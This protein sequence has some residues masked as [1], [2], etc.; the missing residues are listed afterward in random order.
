MHV[1]AFL[2]IDLI[3]LDQADDV[4]CLIQLTAPM[5]LEITQRPG[6]ALVIVLDRSGS[7]SGEPLDGALE[8]IAGLVRRLAPQDAFGLVTFDSQADVVVPV[9]AMADHDAAELDR[10]IRGIRSGGSTDLS[11]GYLLGVREA[12]RALHVNGTAGCSGIVGATVLLVSDGH[13]NAGI[14]DPVVM[15]GLAHAANADHAITTSTLGFGLGY[16]EVLLEAITRGGNGEHRFA[17]DVD[18]CMSE[19]ADAATDLLGKSVLGALLRIMPQPGLVGGVTVRNDVPH[20]VEG[21]AVVVNIGDLYGGEERR[22]LFRLHVPALPSLGLATIADVVLEFTSLPDLQ[23]HS[24]T[25][26]VSVNVVPGDQAAGRIPDPRVQVEELLVD[27]DAAKKGVSMSL[28]SGDATTARRTLGDSIISVSGKRDELKDSP[29]TG[30]TARLGEAAE[31][32]L[33]LADDV[34]HQTAEYASKS[35]MSSYAATSRGRKVKGATPSSAPI[36]LVDEDVD[37]TEGDAR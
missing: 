33:R 6:Q 1:N 7:M 24:V 27:V 16:D 26:P 18:T 23:Q 11:A 32:L 17:P 3:A 12:A 30:L 31:E 9:R 4:T 25:I 10:A 20:W 2:D 34:L 37:G 21:D 5:P 13:A 15:A 35:A 19:I 28:R 8:A 14:E 29:D 22:T 36:E